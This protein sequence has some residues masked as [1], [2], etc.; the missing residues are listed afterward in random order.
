MEVHLFDM[1][2]TKD[3]CMLTQ[4]SNESCTLGQ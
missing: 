2:S 4:G 3:K 1:H